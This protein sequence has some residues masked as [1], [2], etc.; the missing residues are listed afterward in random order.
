MKLT[1]F[2]NNTDDTT[3]YNKIKKNDILIKYIIYI[4]IY[5][6]SSYGDNRIIDKYMKEKYH[7]NQVKLI[8]YDTSK[9]VI[10]TGFSLS[11]KVNYSS[12]PTT[13]TPSIH[14]YS[15]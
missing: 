14:H 3:I 6:M 8:K 9:Q 2:P 7:E 12:T 5:I 13:N 15:K 10:N 1:K 11:T 4:I